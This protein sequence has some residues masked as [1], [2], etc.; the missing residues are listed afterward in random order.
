[1]SSIT[2]GNGATITA[3]TIEAFFSGAI[4]LL[5]NLEADVTRNPS[6]INNITSSISDDTRALTATINLTAS[7]DD[8]SNGKAVF[9][10]LDYLTTPIGGTAHWIPGTGGT[11]SSATIQGAIFEAARL[12]DKLENTVINNPTAKKCVSYTINS[13]DIG[14]SGNAGININVVNFPL[15]FSFNTNGVQSLVGTEYLT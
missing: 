4:W 10:A 5:Q 7:I 6:G 13:G 15:T 9:T 12:I 14:S 2:P 11:I 8:D 1:M 3:S